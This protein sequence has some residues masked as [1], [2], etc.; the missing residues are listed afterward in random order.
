MTDGT[1][2]LVTEG[3]KPIFKKNGFVEIHRDDENYAR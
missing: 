1:S 2:C 3:Y